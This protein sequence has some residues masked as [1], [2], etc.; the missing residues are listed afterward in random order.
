MFAFI[1]SIPAPA[2][3]TPFMS[4]IEVAVRIEPPPAEPLPALLPSTLEF[5]TPAKAE[6]DVEFELTME[7]PEP[8]SP[9]P[10]VLVLTRALLLTVAVAVLEVEVAVMIDPPEVVPAPAMLSTTSNA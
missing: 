4:P 9:A 1:K 5:A 3:V 2:P 6:L 8:V 7:P 10:A